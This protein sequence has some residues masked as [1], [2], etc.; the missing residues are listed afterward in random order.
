MIPDWYEVKMQYTK[1]K[2]KRGRLYKL[3]KKRIEDAF[4][5][6]DRV[7]TTVCNG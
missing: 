7:D 6:N 3:T 1:V 4:P 2:G 5:L